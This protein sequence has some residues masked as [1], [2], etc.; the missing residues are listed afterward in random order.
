MD[1][2]DEI[3]AMNEAAEATGDELAA[4]FR[5]D[6]SLFAELSEV[7][8]AESMPEMDEGEIASTD[9][10]RFN[11]ATIEAQGLEEANQADVGRFLETQ[12]DIW[13]AQMEFN[14]TAAGRMGDYARRI[15][16]LE[17]YVQRRRG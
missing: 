7:S 6:M 16:D 15:R 1:G 14:E 13:D 8:H 10:A 3:D 17:Q 9:E 4:A 11:R 2:D 5:E 12:N